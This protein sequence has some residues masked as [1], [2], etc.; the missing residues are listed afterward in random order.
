M[1]FFSVALDRLKHELRVSKDQEV[2]ALLGLSKTAF[3]ERK[4]RGSFPEREVLELG[5]L[6]PDVDVNYVLT[7]IAS[8]AQARL[9]A[10]QNR[11]SQAVDAG[12]DFEQARAHELASDKASIES[13]TALLLQCRVC[14]REAVHQLLVNIVNLRNELYAQQSAGQ[15][16]EAKN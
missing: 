10:K 12:M 8:S 7:G 3:S 1:N 11:I 16:R 9:D 2:A 4:K 13:I 15:K 6:R 5:K 14:E